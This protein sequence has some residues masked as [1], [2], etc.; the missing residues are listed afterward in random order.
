MILL[1]LYEELRPEPSSWTLVLQKNLWTYLNGTHRKLQLILKTM[2]V[3]ERAYV[4]ELTTNAANPWEAKLD[5]LTTID[6]H[7]LAIGITIPVGQDAIRFTSCSILRLCID[8]L[9]PDQQID[10]Q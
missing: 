9:W 5:E 7:L 1:K 10:C 3:N 8:T 4:R 2:S 6:K